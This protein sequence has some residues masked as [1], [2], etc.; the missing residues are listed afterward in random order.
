MHWGRPPRVQN[1]RRLWKYYLAPTSLRAG[2][3]LAPFAI[4]FVLILCSLWM[5]NYRIKRKMQ[6]WSLTQER[7]PSRRSSFFHFHAVFCKILVKQVSIPVG[8]VPSACWPC[9]GD[10]GALCTH[11]RP[12]G[13]PPGQD[14]QTPVKT[15]PCPKLR[16]YLNENELF[17]CSV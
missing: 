11:P 8:C 14:R 17:L 2:N 12:S 9:P 7:A 6:I 1:H 13:T 5:K 10:R 16:L 3:D 4:L 15:L